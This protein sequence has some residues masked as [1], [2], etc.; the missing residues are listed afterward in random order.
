M[1]VHKCNI[2][3]KEITTWIKYDAVIATDQ[4]RPITNP[5][6]IHIPGLG[7][8]ELCADCFSDI[9]KQIEAKS[10]RVRDKI[11]EFDNLFFND[12]VVEIGI[13]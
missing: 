9:G 4:N 11:D 10:V 5:S 3:R 7:H 6:R 1:L 12:P 2:C 13:F 8:K